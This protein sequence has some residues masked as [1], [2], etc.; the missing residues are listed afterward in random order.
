MAL[1]NTG[2]GSGKT[3]LVADLTEEYRKLNTVLERTQTLSGGITSNISGS[4][5][6]GGGNS[7]SSMTAPGPSGPGA[8]SF[9]SYNY[10][11]PGT[12]KSAVYSMAG[13]TLA[14][15]ATASTPADYIT[16]D[17]SRRRFGFFS[18]AGSSSGVAAFNSMNKMGSANSPLDAAAAAGAGNSMGLTA[19]LMN[20]STVMKSAAGISN[21]TPGIGLENAMGATA[22]LNQG[23]SVNKLRMIGINV[24]DQNGYMRDVESIARDLWKSI[25]ISKQG[26]SSISESDL[27]YSLQSGNSL[28]MLLNQYF[29]SDQ[30]L[31]QGVISYLFQFVKEKGIPQAGGYTS[32]AGKNMLQATGALPEIQRSISDRNNAEYGAINAFTSAGITGIEQGN[33]VVSGIANMLNTKEMVAA[34]SGFVTTFTQLDQIA[35]AANGS[36]GMLVGGLIQ[37][38]DK[39]KNIGLW[40]TG[41]DAAANSLGPVNK[42]INDA[43]GTGAD[44]STI[45]GITDFV[46][47]AAAPGGGNPK[48]KTAPKAYSVTKGTSNA[49]KARSTWAVKALT[50][51]GAPLTADNIAAL[52]AWET[53][54]NTGAKNNPL[55]TTQ[56]LPGVK[57]NN[58]NSAGVQNYGTDIQGIQAFIATLNNGASGYDQILKDLYSG[59]ATQD[60][61]L[62]DVEKSAWSGA[63]HYGHTFVSVNLPNVHDVA[64]QAVIDKIKAIFTKINDSKHV[65]GN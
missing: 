54:E 21:M 22:A 5:P 44:F 38:I 51:M 34:A 30:V 14:A 32:A 9:P 65:R 36:L 13:T 12:S 62:T 53:R 40:V 4:S 47:G 33:S 16:N 8:P 29:G 27:S 50:A 6:S 49:T 23:S 63:S 56:S 45:Q 10:T 25:N 61:I 1:P 64:D 57:R 43:V 37:G 58:F 31:R 7:M 15:I 42:Y 3:R 26:K 11:E 52:S 41:L 17:I 20:Y 48:T 55:A 46:T 39:L 19:G 18:G 59:T 24:R 28:D 35:G 60:T 2:P